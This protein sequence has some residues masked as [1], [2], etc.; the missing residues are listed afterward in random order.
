MTNDAHKVDMNERRRTFIIG[1]IVSF[2]GGA[3]CIAVLTYQLTGN[4]PSAFL[5]GGA[6]LFAPLGLFYGMGYWAVGIKRTL[7][8]VR[9]R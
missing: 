3:L 4:G 2:V 6:A 1:T 5:A 9:D 8:E 7:R